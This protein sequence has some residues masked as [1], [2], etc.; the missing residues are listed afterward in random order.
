MRKLRWACLALLGCA[1]G[2]HAKPP[3]SALPPL[4]QRSIAPEKAINEN[5]RK[6]FEFAASA[7]LR[8]VIC[9]D[10]VHPEAGNAILVPTDEP[11][12]IWAESRGN[13]QKV[14]SGGGFG[15]NP[16]LLRPARAGLELTEELRG[17]GKNSRLFPYRRSYLHCDD[18]TCSQSAARCALEPAF[19]AY[20]RGLPGTSQENYRR[21][22]TLLSLDEDALE[23]VDSIGRPLFL[24]SLAGDR[25]AEKTLVELSEKFRLDGANSEIIRGLLASLREARQSGCR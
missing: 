1:V 10:H 9:A 24:K 8:L 2:A 4:T 18:V 25:N 3:V 12:E 21:L 15:A 23:L 20:A 17:A 5:C 11:V 6:I 14:F 19:R 7:S 13:Y 22:Q 16:L